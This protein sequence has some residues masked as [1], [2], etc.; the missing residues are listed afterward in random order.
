MHLHSQVASSSSPSED[1]IQIRKFNISREFGL[2]Q[3]LKISSSRSSDMMNTKL[4]LETNKHTPGRINIKFALVL[5]FQT[6]IGSQFLTCL[7]IEVK[8]KPQKSKVRT[9][10]DLLNSVPRQVL[11][12][13]SNRFTNKLNTTLK[14]GTK[15][16]TPGR[17]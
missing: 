7:K 11:K 9:S 8:I 4:Q 15:K 17:I 3:G 6:Q 16:C 10:R 14:L 1:N 13:A 2:R 5:E 12:V